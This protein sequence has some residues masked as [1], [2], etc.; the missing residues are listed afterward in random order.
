MQQDGLEQQVVQDGLVLLEV[1]EQLGQLVIPE[2][3]EVQDQ[4]VAQDGPEQLEQLE[5][6]DL[7]VH[8]LAQVFLDLVFLTLKQ[9]LLKI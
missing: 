2:Q 1:Q 9:L 8:I 5:Q 3:L 7:Q 4:L 6:L